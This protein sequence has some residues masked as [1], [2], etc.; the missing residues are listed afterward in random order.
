MAIDDVGLEQFGHTRPSVSLFYNP[1]FRALAFQ[2]VL[3]VAIIVCIIWFVDNTV[4]NLR[5]A[6]I[7]SGFEF[8]RNRSG[9]DISQSLIPYS[10]ESTYGRALIVGLLNTLLVSAIGV[11]LASI[12]GFLLGIAR[13]SNN[14]LIAKLATVYVEVF[15]NVPVLLQLLLW[16]KAVLSLLPGPRQGYSLPLS[17]N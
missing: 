16:Y 3:A 17:S 14:W 8:L 11:V 12:I 9:F 6:N 4:D 2:I 10:T 7:A 15:R 13:L 1:R 5:R